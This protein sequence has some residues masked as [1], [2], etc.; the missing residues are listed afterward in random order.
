M[1]AIRTSYLDLS[2]IL[3]KDPAVSSV[4]PPTSSAF[5]TAR[6]RRVNRRA[7]NELVVERS[8]SR[9][10]TESRGPVP[11]LTPGASSLPHPPGRPPALFFRT[12]PPAIP[13][14]IAP[15]SAPSQQPRGP[16]SA[17]PRPPPPPPPPAWQELHG[18]PHPALEA[19]ALPNRARMPWKYRSPRVA[20]TTVMRDLG[21]LHEGAGRRLPG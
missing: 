16:P 6:P 14:R 9:G 13:A 7:H 17:A 8:G 10:A 1:S 12:A 2:T 19:L 11:P 3:Y 15:L 20:Q 4:V 5:G 21:L 18:V